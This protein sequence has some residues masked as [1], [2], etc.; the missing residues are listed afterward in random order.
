[1]LEEECIVPKA[2]DMTYLEKMMNKHL[3]NHKSFGKPKPDQ[4]G[5][6]PKLTLKCITTPELLVTMSLDGSSRTR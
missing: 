2:T 1:M 4:K 6:N 5:T 3:G